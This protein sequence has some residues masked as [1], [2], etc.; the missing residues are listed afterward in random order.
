[1]L[2]HVAWFEVSLSPSRGITL[3]VYVDLTLLP[4]QCITS[5][6]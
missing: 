3:L 6:C 4:G 2:S 1:M 5:L